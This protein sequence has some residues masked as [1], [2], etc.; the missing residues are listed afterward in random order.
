M[1]AIKESDQ[2]RGWESGLLMPP[3]NGKPAMF[4]ITTFT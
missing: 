1:A 3:A 4:K 2:E